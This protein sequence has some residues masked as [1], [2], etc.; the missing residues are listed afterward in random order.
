MGDIKQIFGL[1]RTKMEN[2]Q[3]KKRKKRDFGSFGSNLY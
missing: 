2:S 1:S 3:Q